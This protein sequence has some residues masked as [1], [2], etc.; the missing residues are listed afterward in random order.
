[1]TPIWLFTLKKQK[2]WKNAAHLL[3]FEEW[4][5]QQ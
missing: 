2:G 5:E 3:L 1:M 4:M